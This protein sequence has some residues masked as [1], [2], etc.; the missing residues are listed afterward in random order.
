M[1]YCDSVI[2]GYC[3]FANSIQLRN[4]EIDEPKR[5]DINK[6]EI[7]LKKSAEKVQVVNFWDTAVMHVR[8]VKE[9]DENLA[10]NDGNQQIAE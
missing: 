4:E 10:C 8:T 7:F 6:F 9:I 5:F 2:L 3:D 1:G